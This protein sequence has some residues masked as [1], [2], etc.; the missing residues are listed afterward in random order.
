MYYRAGAA[1]FE[2]DRYIQDRL[3]CCLRESKFETLEKHNERKNAVWEV[4][5]RTEVYGYTHVLKY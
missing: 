5:S 3:Q 4:R 2:L 1:Y